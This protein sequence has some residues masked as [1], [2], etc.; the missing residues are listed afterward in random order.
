MTLVTGQEM[1]WRQPEAVVRY[2]E[3]MH[4]AHLMAS[5]RFESRCGSL[6]RGECDGRTWTLKRTGFFAPRV[7]VR[8]A[9]SEADVA[10]FTPG[11]MGGGWVAFPA[12]PRYHLRATD[13][14]R[15]EW[16]FET[17]DGRALLTLAGRPH[18]FKD[19]GAATIAP[20]AAGLPETPVLLLLMWYVRVL[21]HEDAS[22]AAVVAA[23]S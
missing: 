7:T 17:E 16:A 5:L 20:P 18:L 2:F 10:V 14:W 23:C 4:D 3:L 21:T 22:A 19:G 11:W 8:V 1:E 13:F 12:G 9:G 15:T 6:A